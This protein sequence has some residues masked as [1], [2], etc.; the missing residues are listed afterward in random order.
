MNRKRGK[1]AFSA[2]CLPAKAYPP[3]PPIYFQNLAGNYLVTPL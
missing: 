3:T 2:K 1:A